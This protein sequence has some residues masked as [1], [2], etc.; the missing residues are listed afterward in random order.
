MKKKERYKQLLE[1]LEHPRELSELVE[2]VDVEKSTVRKY[3][4]QLVDKG[5]AKRVQKGIY[6]RT[7]E[8]SDWLSHEADNQGTQK[9]KPSSSSTGRDQSLSH[10]YLYN[11]RPDL[12]ISF[13]LTE[14]MDEHPGK[15]EMGFCVGLLTVGVN[16]LNKK[17][18]PWGVVFTGLGL[19]VG[20]D[21]FVRML[22]EKGV[23]SLFITK[24]LE[25]VEDAELAEEQDGPSPDREDKPKRVRATELVS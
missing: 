15:L 14:W 23:E 25:G 8:G 9:K 2:E 6:R 1:N 17:D 10:S 11:N 4:G 13:S 5:R 24:G 7:D 21:G 19:V 18:T 20:V 22:K 16:F 12:P 3:L